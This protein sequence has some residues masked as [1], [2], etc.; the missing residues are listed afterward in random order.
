ML[1]VLVSGD[2]V[3]APGP[4]P[5][6]APVALGQLVA[7]ESLHQYTSSGGVQTMRIALMAGACLRALLKRCIGVSLL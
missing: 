6:H 4:H 7:A 3:V 2:A 1:L 5:L